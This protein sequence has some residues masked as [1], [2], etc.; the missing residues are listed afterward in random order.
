M[1]MAVGSA[2]SVWQRKT[3]L[4]GTACSSFNLDGQTVDVLDLKTLLITRGINVPEEITGQFGRTH[5]LAPTSDPF[6]CNCLLLPGGIPAHMFHVGPDADFSLA[7]NSAG[8]P[9]LTYRGQPVTQVDFPPATRF[10]EQ[11][12]RDG[13]PFRMMAVLQGLDV[14]SFPY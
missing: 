8:S 9:C 10:Y 12:T 4:F 11:Q 7:V 5:R 3:D 14:V 1:N 2:T 6:A 13:F